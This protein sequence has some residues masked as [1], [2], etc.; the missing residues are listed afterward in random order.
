[1]DQFIV[2]SN[3]NTPLGQFFDVGTLTVWTKRLREKLRVTWL[4]QFPA[5]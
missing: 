2:T 4:V 3:G 5:F 1:M